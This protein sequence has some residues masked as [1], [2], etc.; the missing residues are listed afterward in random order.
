L[1][2]TLHI[3]ATQIAECWEAHSLNKN[4]KSLDEHSFAGFRSQL[5]KTTDSNV[6]LNETADGGAVVR[7]AKKKHEASGAIVTPAPNKRQHVDGG[8]ASS[9]SSSGN[10]QSGNRRVSMSPHTP[11][12]TGNTSTAQA[13]MYTYENRKGSG[14]VVTEYNPA[15]LQAAPTTTDLS[16]ARCRVN[17]DFATN[18]TEAYRHY[19]TVIDERAVALDNRLLEMHDEFAEQFKFGTGDLADLEAVNVPRQDK[20]C[21]IGR[22]CNAVRRHDFVYRPLAFVL[23]RQSHNGFVAGGLD[24]SHPRSFARAVSGLF[25][26][27]ACRHTKAASTRPLSCWRDRVTCRAELGSNSTWP[28]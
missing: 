28:T 6:F 24:V 15:K 10:Q 4:L 12:S 5:I 8:S 14:T 18:V 3:G 2:S 21:C 1:A 22:V 9:S 7:S 27:R 13:S 16:R 23:D 20:I 19:F 17:H 25:C 26:S 11:Q